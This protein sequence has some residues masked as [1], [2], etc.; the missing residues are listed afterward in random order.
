MGDP[1]ALGASITPWRWIETITSQL[2]LCGA[3][4]GET[5]VVL[6]TDLGDSQLRSLVALAFE[7]VGCEVLEVIVRSGSIFDGRDPVA[8]DAV[9]STLINA[10]IVVDLGAGLIEKSSA[11]DELL[12][13][14]RVL[15]LDVTSTS[16]LDHL[17]AHPG[18]ER[19]LD[20]ATALLR[21]GRTMTVTST[22]GTSLEIDLADC[23][24]HSTS[25]LV[26]EQG[27]IAHWPAGAVWAHP[28]ETAVSGSVIAMPGDLVCETNHVM[29]SP[30]RI[31][32][33]N[34]R[35]VEVLGDTMDADVL[36]SHLEGLADETAY[37]VTDVGWGMNFTRHGSDLGVFDAGQVAVGRGPLAAGRVNLRTG[38]HTAAQQVGVTLSLA[39]GSVAIDDVLIV[40][41]GTLEG[42]IAPDVYERA[43]G[44]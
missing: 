35:V 10:S 28:N 4:A 24:I 29:R 42:A 37:R 32:L 41:D 15:V 38:H 23:E 27:Q 13:E 30:V 16:Q 9:A 8:G 21:T 44:N 33:Q 19:R 20:R 14:T 12:E 7:R 3:T 5:A 25:G 39:H 31:E 11:R 26:K 22:A 6:S 36:R 18:L 2:E 40:S 1:Q 17:V 34:G 43:A